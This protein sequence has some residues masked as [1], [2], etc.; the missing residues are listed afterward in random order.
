MSKTNKVSPEN[1]TFQYDPDFEGPIKNRSCTD[2]ICCLLFIIFIGG[3]AI[4][5]YFAFKYG[6]P[7]LLLNPVNSDGEMCGKGNQEGKDYLFF[8]DMVT[9]GRMGVGVFVKGC[10]TPQ[11]CVSQCPDA[12]FIYKPAPLGD[13]TQFNSVYC[14]DSY[15]SQSLSDIID[16]EIC[17]TYYLKSEPVIKRCTPSILVDFIDNAGNLLTK[18]QGENLTGVE[19][20]SGNSLT[21]DI[22]ESG[23]DAF[24]IFLKA[25]E[26]AEK[27][28]EDVVTTWWMILLGILIAMILSLTW[29]II[30]RWIAGI[31]VW[32]T[33]FA[34]VGAFG[35]ATYYCLWNYFQLKDTNETFTMNFSV[36]NFSFSKPKML[37]AF[38]IIAGIILTIILLILLF[39][40]SRIRIAIAL[41]KEGSRAVGTMMF[42]LIWPLIPFLL[43]LIVFGYWLT[44]AVYLASTGRAQSFAFNNKSVYAY[45]NGS[46]KFDEI[47]SATSQLFGEVC[48][49]N[50][51]NE[52]GS[53]FCTFLKNQ[54]EN[55]VLYSQIYNLFMLF[56]LINFSIALGQMVLAGA[57]ASYY[58]TFFKPEDLPLFPLSGSLWRAFRYHIGSLAFGSLIIA[59]IQM[60]RVV[61]EYLDHKIKGKENPLAKVLLKCLK[62]CFWCLEKVMKFLNKNA[63]IMI[64]AHGKNFCTSAKNVFMLILRNIVRVVVIDKVT[65][66]L[67]FI[68]IL[69]VVAASGAFAFLFFDGRI[70]F[71]SS[72]T[73][74]LNFYVVPIVLVI[75]GAYII[76]SAFF[77]VYGMAV[78]TLF[79]CF[80]E[81]LE[82]ND[83]S[84]DKPYYMSS[85]L[86]KI[87]GK[88]N[89]LA[90][91]DSR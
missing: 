2:I 80:L 21:N 64:A 84:A 51:A 23:L 19:D 63:Y 67:L 14:K 77:S 85:Q 35:Y 12:N 16:Q 17:P 65:D 50:S 88:K 70:T 41:I 32:F 46:W 20:S 8:F 25:K 43:Q 61:L 66:F 79:L 7:S 81:D 83:G 13:G 38:G 71:L 62:C 9:C 31:M 49:D 53:E 39:L 54:E 48:D 10:P 78:D 58:W 82:R 69:V 74:T 60:M 30:M 33:I 44:I 73:P 40:C 72:Y 22:I 6:D 34:F 86:M 45:P 37:L 11:I 4:I 1:E 52:T 28:I 91:R 5:S 47:T 87:V 90:R 26:Y 36:V 18:V 15:A 59:I 55:F 68:G 75:I 29:I 3:L 56:W 57:F 42:T 27:I 24:G 76:A 89:V